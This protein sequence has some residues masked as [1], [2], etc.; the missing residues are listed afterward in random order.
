M[1]AEDRHCICILDTSNMPAR[2]IR[3]CSLFTC[4]AEGMPWPVTADWMT[5]KGF[6]CGLVANNL[7]FL[8]KPKPKRL[9]YV[10]L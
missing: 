3:R 4:R 6:G 2:R 10:E 5:S 1:R 8:S 7:L 9:L